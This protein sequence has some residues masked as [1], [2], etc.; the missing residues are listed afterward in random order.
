MMQRIEACIYR[1]YRLTT[2]IKRVVLFEVPEIPSQEIFRHPIRVYGV[3]KY[4]REDR[5]IG[6]T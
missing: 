3:C 4:A 5:K 2:M 6:G 1:R